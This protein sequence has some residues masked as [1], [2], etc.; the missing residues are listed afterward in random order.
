MVIK[1]SQT[2]HKGQK[3]RISYKLCGLAVNMTKL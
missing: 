2:V 3:I 1:R